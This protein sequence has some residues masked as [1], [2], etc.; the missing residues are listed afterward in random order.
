MS[1]SPPIK[2]TIP[3]ERWDS[4]SYQERDLDREVVLDRF[5]SDPSRS[6]VSRVEVAL[7]ID[8]F[9]IYW[10]RSGSSMLSRLSIKWSKSLLEVGRDA[11][12]S[13]ELARWLMKPPKPSTM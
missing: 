11:F 6:D 9:S 5:E 13:L 12:G 2:F 1:S 7:K 8:I 4:S 3:L 10:A